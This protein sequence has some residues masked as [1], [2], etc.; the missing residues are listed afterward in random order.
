MMKKFVF[1]VASLMMLTLVACGHVDG[2]PKKSEIDMVKEVTLAPIHLTGTT[3]CT[4]W[5]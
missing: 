1:A 4:Y 2:G 3:L 5:E